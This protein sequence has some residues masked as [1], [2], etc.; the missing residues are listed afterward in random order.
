MSWLTRDAALARLG[1][2]PQTLYAYVSRG[3]IRSQPAEDDPR[4]SVYSGSDID[5]FL[6]RRRTGRA[7]SAIAEGTI[8]WGDPVMQTAITTVRDGQLIY[9]GTDAVTLAETATLEEA[10]AL[11]WQ[12]D[13]LDTTSTLQSPA[14][15]ETGKARLLSWLATRAA[16]DLPGHGRSPA[17]LTRDGAVILNGAA[18][19]ITR[20]SGP[21]AFHSRLASYWLVRDEA[22]DLIRRA[23]VLVADHELNPSTFAA[24]VAASTGSSLAAAALA[25]C[26]TLTGPR[27]GEASARALAYLKAACRDGPE[28]ALGAIAAR[29]EYMAAVGH[30]LYPDGDPRA[31]ALLDWMGLGDPLKAAIEAAQDASGKL[32]NVDMALAALT[33]KLGLPD[34]A[35]FL[36]FASGRIV[37]WLAHAMEQLT[38]GQLIRPRA[39]YTGD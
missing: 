18:E 7:R 19:A 1:V 35:P 20:S 30:A 38:S 13:S 8:A 12:A 11:L 2:K 32:A 16:R 17:V 24:R 23:L 4:S 33:L 37:G 3:L 34:D 26:A 39:T 9:R 10:A 29:G 14:R 36:L 21:D 15:G 31:R 5:A 25:G 27:H 22:G 28:A 6:K